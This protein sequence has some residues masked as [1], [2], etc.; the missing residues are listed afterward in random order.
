M[1]STQITPGLADEMEALRAAGRADTR[2]PVIIA[3]EPPAQSGEAGDIQAVA[4]AI[5][6]AQETVVRRL[7]RLGV[8]DVQRQSLASAIEADLT[9][10]QI[11]AVAEAPTVRSVMLNRVVRVTTDGH[12][13]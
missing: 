4:A 10:A 1:S 13:S 3:V 8:T 11:E 9:P 2:L 12:E 5:H 6:T 7:A